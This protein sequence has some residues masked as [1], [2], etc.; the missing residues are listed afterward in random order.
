M[1]AITRFVPPEL[2]HEA[3]REVR[4]Y[5]PPLFSG[6]GLFPVPFTVC[7]FGHASLLCRFLPS[8]RRAADQLNLY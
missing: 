2:H 3:D 8:L 6:Q 5:S 4:L 7:A 1:Q